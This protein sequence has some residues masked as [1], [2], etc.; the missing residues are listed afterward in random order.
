MLCKFSYNIFVI[1]GI[2]HQMKT[3]PFDLDRLFIFHTYNLIPALHDVTQGSL[4]LTFTSK[5]ILC[6]FE[7]ETFYRKAFSYIQQLSGSS[8]CIVKCILL[9][10]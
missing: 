4:H 9:F 5:E 10:Y 6:Y 2:I 8:G 3:K 1:T 7:G